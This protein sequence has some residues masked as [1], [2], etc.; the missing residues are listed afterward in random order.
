MVGYP[1]EALWHERLLLHEVRS[2]VWVILTP[3]EDM[4][5][6][7][8][9]GCDG[10]R[11]CGPRRELPRGVLAGESYR[12]GQPWYTNSEL[13]DLKRE[14]KE[15]AEFQKG[16]PPEPPR[17]GLQ[18]RIRGKTAARGG[19]GSHDSEMVKEKE[20]DATK[21]IEEQARMDEDLK[22]KP[23]R[24]GLPERFPENDEANDDEG[25]ERPWLVVGPGRRLGFTLAPTAKVSRVGDLGVYEQGGECYF[26]Q[27][28]DIGD[29][30]KVIGEIAAQ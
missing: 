22:S 8:L 9:N 4:Y 1:D 29:E 14:A 25:D 21:E 7:D 5:I 2:G 30:F 6:E 28:V 26:V 3:D 23:P 20:T 12:F 10:F 16:E 27:K 19:K 13:N 24:K 18:W 11:V 17:R 15:L